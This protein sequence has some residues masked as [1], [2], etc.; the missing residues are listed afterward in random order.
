MLL[1]TDI[2]ISRR[3]IPSSGEFYC[4]RG[5]AGTTGT[6][7][8]YP[9]AGPRHRPGQRAQ[10]DQTERETGPVPGPAGTER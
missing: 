4:A 9:R 2:Y 10:A 5:T 3:N 7:G 6:T 1:S 8:T